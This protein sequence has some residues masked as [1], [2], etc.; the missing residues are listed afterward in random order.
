VETRLAG[1]ELD[2]HNYSTWGVFDGR[3]GIEMIDKEEENEGSRVH[4]DNSRT[5]PCS[6]SSR[7]DQRHPNFCAFMPLRGLSR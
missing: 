4:E 6:C 3:D 7:P 2:R 5:P 1:S